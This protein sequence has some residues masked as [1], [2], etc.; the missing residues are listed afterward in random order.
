MVEQLP[1]VLN[2][3]PYSGNDITKYESP[4]VTRG[5][6]RWSHIVGEQQKEVWKTVLTG[7]SETSIQAQ[8][9]EL[10]RVV[11]DDLVDRLV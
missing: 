10:I 6:D 2:Y 8:L 5:A 9:R 11:L 4:S 3:D 1:D 7:L